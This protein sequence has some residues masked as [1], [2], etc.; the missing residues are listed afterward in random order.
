MRR[1]RSARAPLLTLALLA[2]A[3]AAAS[4][5]SEEATTTQAVTTA[6][7]AQSS[8][9]ETS[10]SAA[11]TPNAWTRLTPSGG[12]PDGRSG[13]AMVFDPTTQRVIIFG[14]Q[15]G[16][17]ALDETWAYSPSADTW[18]KLDPTGSTPPTRYHFSMVW[19]PVSQRVIMFGGDKD[20][21]NS[22]LLNDTWAYDPIADSWTNLRPTNPPS[23]RWGHAVVYDSV[24]QRVILV[25]GQ[26]PTGDLADM[27]AYDPKGNTW[28]ELTPKGDGTTWVAHSM[29]YDSLSSQVIA[30]G[31]GGGGTTERNETWVYD[32]KGNAWT[33]VRP[34]GTLPETRAFSPMVYDPTT[35]RAFIFGGL[36]T[37]GAGALDDTWAYNPSASTWTLLSPTGTAPSARAAQAMACDQS[38]GRIYMFGGEATGAVLDDTWVYGRSA[39]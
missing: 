34:S 17:V 15:D 30:F 23:A 27:W 20:V 9:T 39:T 32:T 1:T 5:S 8:A 13:A 22:Q 10:T 33:K 14:G 26:D 7:Q 3:L 4:C 35:D 21:T 12:G 18:T 16:R 31:G 29:A 25:G 11:L 37:E 28:R 38:S 19:D 6:A 36:F 24:G 2:L